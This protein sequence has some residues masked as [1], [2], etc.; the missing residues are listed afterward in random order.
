[1]TALV[2]LTAAILQSGALASELPE[3]SLPEPVMPIPETLI[4]KDEVYTRVNK[5][6]FVMDLKVGG[7]RDR[8]PVISMCE[9]GVTWVPRKGWQATKWTWNKAAAVGDKIPDGI[10]KIGQ[11]A[12]IGA[13]FVFGFV[14]R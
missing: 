9:R 13:P 12:Q 14:R 3:V 5:Q 6:P 11:A 8:H 2:I 10:L 1:M 4:Y 7:F